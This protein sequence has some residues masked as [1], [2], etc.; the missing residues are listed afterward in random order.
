MSNTT[1]TVRHFVEGDF[2]ATPCQCGETAALVDWLV[3]SEGAGIQAKS[4]VHLMY[5][6]GWCYAK[7]EA[8]QEL[9]YVWMLNPDQLDVTRVFPGD[10]MVKE[11]KM[12]ID[13]GYVPGVWADVREMESLKDILTKAATE[14]EHTDGLGDWYAA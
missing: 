1:P 2:D 10:G 13:T 14:Q 8:K 3:F 6:C 4:Y 12:L 11:Y 5:E 9:R 7:S